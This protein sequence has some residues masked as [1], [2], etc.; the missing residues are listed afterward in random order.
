MLVLVSLIHGVFSDWVPG[1]ECLAGGE[2]YLLGMGGGLLEERSCPK[3]TGSEDL[4]LTWFTWP[5]EGY[6]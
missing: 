4:V 3:E 6:H 2:A 5:A 1:G